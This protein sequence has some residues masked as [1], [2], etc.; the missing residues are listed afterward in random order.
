MPTSQTQEIVLFWKISCVVRTLY[1]V[2]FKI[3]KK[4]KLVRM[5]LFFVGF[6]VIVDAKAVSEL[7]NGGRILSTDG[8][9][10]P[11]KFRFSFLTITI[12]SF[13]FNRNRYHYPA[14]G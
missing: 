2:H 3:F 8:E 9:Y 12:N 13:K 6:A 7:L 10:I 4:M 14:R 11:G 1:S 5:T